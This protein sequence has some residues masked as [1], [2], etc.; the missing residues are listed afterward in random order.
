MNETLY[1]REEAAAIFKVGPRTIDRWI[2][3]GALHR[4]NTPGRVV[5]IP[6]SEITRL[7]NQQ[8]PEPTIET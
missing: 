4:A 7:L 2:R 5:R 8:E 6:A 3:E 1:T